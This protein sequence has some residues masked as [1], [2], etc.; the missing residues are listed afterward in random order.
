MDNARY[1]LENGPD[2]VRLN[3][4]WTIMSDTGMWRCD[5]RVLSDQYVVSNGSLVRQDHD[6]I[7][8]PIIRDIQLA[9][10]GKSSFP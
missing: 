6:V 3:I 2:V 7:G 5:I 1:N 10:I 4:T 8:T 9:I